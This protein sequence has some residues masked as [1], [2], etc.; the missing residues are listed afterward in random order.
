MGQFKYSKGEEEVNKVLK[1]NRDLSE[2]IQQD[3]KNTRAAADK[4]IADSE[5]ILRSLGM[6]NEVDLA[7]RDAKQDASSAHRWLSEGCKVSTYPHRHE[8]P[9]CKD[10]SGIK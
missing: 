5:A 10:T 8:H 9:G 4:S 6:G 7:Y 2:E 1:L 3:M